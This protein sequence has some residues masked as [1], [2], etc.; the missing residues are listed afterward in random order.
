MALPALSSHIPTTSTLNNGSTK[1]L[2]IKKPINLCALYKDA[3]L[4]F[5]KDGLTLIYGDNGSGKSSYSRLLK[6]T[7]W[8]RDKDVSL[9][10]NVHTGDTS[11]Q[12]V[13]LT[14][15][16]NGSEIDFDWQVGLD[17]H[18]ALNSIYVFDSK[19]STIYIN[20]ENPSE[21]KPAGID[22]LDS[23]IV[24]CEQLDSKINSELRSL[25][26]T[27]PILN[28][29]YAN[30]DINSWYGSIENATKNEID[31]KLLFTDALSERKKEIAGLLQVSNPIERKNTLSQKGTRYGTFCR[32]ITEIESNFISEKL[33]S[34]KSARNDYLTKK[35][36]YETAKN[37]LNG[38]DPLQGVGSDTWRLLWEAAKK[39]AITEI[40][41]ES[42]SYPNHDKNKICV[43][44]QQPLNEDAQNRLLRFNAF[45]Q[46]QTSKAFGS[47]KNVI[48]GLIKSIESISVPVSDTCDELQLEIPEFEELFSQFCQQVKFAKSTILGY[49]NS[50]EGDITLSINTLSSLI[51]Q[52]IL[53]I[54][55]DIIA[56]DQIITDR[57]KITKELLEIEALEFLSNNKALIEQYWQ[58]CQL[59]NQLTGSKSKT[60]TNSISLEIG[61]IL[62]SQAIIL[63]HSEFIRHL[64]DLNPA[65]SAKV[66]IR[67]TRTSQGQ[68]YQKCSFASITDSLESILSEGEQKVV[69]LANFLSEC[70]I[71]GAVNSI[72]FDDPVNSLDQNY[73]EAIAKK[74]V[75]LSMDRQVIVLTH[76]LY[77]L[78][79]L[80]DVHKETKHN[81]CN[82]IGLSQVGGISG[83]PS[84][85]IPYL[86]KNAQQRIDTIAKGLDCIKA[87]S[88]TDVGRRNSELDSVRQRMRLLLERTIEEIIVNKTIERFSKNIHLRAGNLS[89]IVV[90]QK[91]DV[92]FLLGLFGKYSLPLHD[93][94]TG[95]IPQLPDESAIRQDLTDY[96]T[97]KDA[98]NERIKTYKTTYGI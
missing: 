78:R 91:C 31:G 21:Y 42:P 86:V 26:T 77:F 41:P 87:I 49:L 16:A 50:D 76:D 30:T 80:M 73:R 69:A 17:T 23:L 6:K 5:A 48:Q 15:E 70:T 9:K 85:E 53:D 58:E 24:L 4:K 65:I 34:I 33:G 29:K 45:V 12:S 95:T 54:E 14:F 25:T 52:R 7:C 40:H 66:V 20:S 74:I 57:D 22:I 83:I 55:K 97:W 64:S 93:G 2:S 94:G 27:K 19:C 75:E 44:C 84:D 1:L 47:A 63:Q 8:S 59:K 39:Y 98:F 56:V 71:D 36:A 79:L 28:A 62:E 46:D 13:K 82:I 61:K 38:N 72:V 88:I 60:K 37:E 81:E 18:A 11:P 10:K 96:K 35:S 92:D 3:E 32:G 90:T 51:Y 89:G 67:K 43:L 68:T